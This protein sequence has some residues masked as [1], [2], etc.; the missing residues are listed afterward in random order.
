MRRVRVSTG[1]A[2]FGE[3]RLL[4]LRCLVRPVLECGGHGLPRFLD[5]LRMLS[6]LALSGQGRAGVRPGLRLGRRDRGSF[7]AL[8]T[9]A[10]FARGDPCK[11]GCAHAL[12]RR[13]G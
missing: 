1:P 6:D 10:L 3:H 8:F 5:L 2:P 13:A 9:T 11:S 12:G 4:V 7:A